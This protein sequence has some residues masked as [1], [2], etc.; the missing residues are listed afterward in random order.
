MALAVNLTVA[1]CPE[2]MRTCIFQNPCYMSCGPIFDIDRAL[3]PIHL[4]SFC[5]KTT[6]DSL[7][8]PYVHMCMNILP[9]GVLQ[10]TSSC[11]KLKSMTCIFFPKLTNSESLK[12][13]A[14]DGDCA[15]RM[16]SAL[17]TQL[18]AHCGTH[19]SRMVYGITFN[20]AVR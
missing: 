16:C 12:V 20:H 19:T 18:R 8:V 6:N 5:V 10:F 9:T 13:L 1:Y 4:F 17:C 11:F 15:E 14:L 7:D 2:C 3:L